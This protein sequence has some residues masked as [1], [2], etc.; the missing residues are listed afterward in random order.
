MK[1]KKSEI[2]LFNRRKG[3]KSLFSLSI[4]IGWDVSDFVVISWYR[5]ALFP[6]DH[7]C[8]CVPLTITMSGQDAR[9]PFIWPFRPWYTLCIFFY[10]LLYL[11]FPLPVMLS[12]SLLLL[13]PI[14]PSWYNHYHYSREGFSDLQPKSG[15]PPYS[16]SSTIYLCLGKLKQLKLTFACVTFKT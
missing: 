13:L 7:V 16:L 11:L 1:V 3:I 4:R 6:S 12:S 10:G 8:S 5:D 14:F 9:G 2:V 15:S